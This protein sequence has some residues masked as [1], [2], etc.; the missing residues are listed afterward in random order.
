M[1]WTNPADHVTSHFT[2]ADAAMLHSFNRL[3]TPADGMNPD[4]LIVLCQKMEQV[5]DVLSQAFGK[6]CPL[7]VH[8]MYRSPEYNKQIGAPPND[9]HSFSEACDFD[10]G[11][12]LTIAQVQAILEPQLEALGIRMERNTPS[13]VHVDVHPVGHAR[14]FYA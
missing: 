14:Y 4:K 13:W 2:V 5:R 8:C 7:N 11:Q 1:D 3:A 10:C 6:D 12:H 9:V